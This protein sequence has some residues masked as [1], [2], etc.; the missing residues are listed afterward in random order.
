[1]KVSKICF[2]RIPEKINN[3]R[4]PGCEKG[5]TDPT[6]EKEGMVGGP[7]PR[8]K[9]RS[10]GRY[11]KDD[12][13]AEGRRVKGDPQG[14]DKGWAASRKGEE[15]RAIP[16]GGIKGGRHHQRDKLWAIPRVGQK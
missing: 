11:S 3:W 5:W 10:G 9:D 2:E 7:L 13:H 14:W 15:W 8:G 1:M 4:S 12:S 6:E 16:K